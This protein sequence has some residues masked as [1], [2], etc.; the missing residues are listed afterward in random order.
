MN[1]SP[2][3]DNGNL[4]LSNPRQVEIKP[5][6]KKSTNLSVQF[7]KAES[8]AASENVVIY[9]N[10]EYIFINQ[11]D[12]V[13]C[14]A[15]GNYTIIHLSNSTLYAICKTLKAFSKTINM[16]KFIRCHHSYLVNGSY[17]DKISQDKR[18][19]IQAQHFECSLPISRRRLTYTL[20]RLKESNY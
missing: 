13:Y 7:N 8:P 18:I 20:G 2:V 19:I 10:G 11:D 9:F 5:K 3:L 14:T 6:N 15:E 1:I 12:I 4:A 17:V 16:R